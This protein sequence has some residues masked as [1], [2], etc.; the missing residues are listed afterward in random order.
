M[1]QVIRMS[2]RRR[3]SFGIRLSILFFAGVGVLLVA[4]PMSYWDQFAPKNTKTPNTIGTPQI[5]VIDADT[6]RANGQVYRLVGFDTP[7]SGLQAKC[8]AERKLAARATSRLRQIV[9]AGGLRFQRVPC[10]CPS[11]TE[12]TQKCN[13]GRLCA[14]LA[15]PAG[16]VGTL[17]IGE[18][19]ARR[20]VCSDTR[21]PQRQ[22]WC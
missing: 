19:L 12:G 13:Y 14:K 21:C 22:G 20:Y 11:G 8:E 6:I 1:A 16:D 10:A 2:P 3:R 4:L 7:E 5:D 15:S 18:G 17:L 9:A